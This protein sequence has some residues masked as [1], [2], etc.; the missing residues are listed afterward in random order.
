MRED[1]QQDAYEHYGCEENGDVKGPPV[2]AH[3]PITTDK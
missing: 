3:K 2:H 1:R